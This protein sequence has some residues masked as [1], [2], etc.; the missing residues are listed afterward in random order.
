[1]LTTVDYYDTFT[2]TAR[3]CSL[4]SFTFTLG[5]GYITVLTLNLEVLSG[6]LVL[7]FYS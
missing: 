3:L 1:M 6:A 7:S 2:R 5:V 4:L